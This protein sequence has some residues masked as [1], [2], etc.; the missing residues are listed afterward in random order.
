M[1]KIIVLLFYFAL[2]VFGSGFGDDAS[3]YSL[4][5]VCFAQSEKARIAFYQ[6]DNLYYKAIS[7][8]YHRT[9]K[10]YHV[11]YSFCHHPWKF[12]AFDLTDTTNV[13]A[14][15]SDTLRIIDSHIYYIVTPSLYEKVS[16]VMVPIDQTLYFFSGLNC[17]RPIHRVRDVIEWLSMRNES[18]DAACMER[19]KNCLSYYQAIP[20]D[21]QGKTPRCECDCKHSNLGYSVKKPRKVRFFL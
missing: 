5:S 1:K 21:P 20:V 12:Y 17:C 6:M 7:K 8:E 3:K 9:L 16:I 18:T 14:K 19:V 4:C 2:S 15:E 13:L 11:Y 10:H